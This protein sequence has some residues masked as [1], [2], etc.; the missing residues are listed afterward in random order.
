MADLKQDRIINIDPSRI[1][2]PR[3]RMPQ[4]CV[5]AGRANEGLRADWQDQLREAKKACG[6]RYIRMH[7]L[8][9][10]DMGVCLRNADGSLSFS[11]QYIDK[12][13]DFLLSIDVKPFVELSFTP[14]ALA[15]NDKTIFWWKGNVS[16]PA[17]LEDWKSLVHAFVQHVTERYGLAEVSQWYFECWNEPDLDGFFTGTQEDYFHL[18]TATTE[19]VKS[20]SPAYRCGGP[21]TSGCMWIKDFLDYCDQ[22]KTA[23]DFIAT[24]TYGVTQGALDEFGNSGTVLAPERDSI[25]RD[26]IRV[27]KIIEASAFPKLELHFT[28]W[29]SS[30][31]PSDPFHDTWQSPAWILERLKQ[32]QGYIDSMSYWVFTDI[33]EEAGP[34]FTPF[35]GGFGLMNLQGIKKAAWYAWAWHNALGPLELDQEDSEAW[36]CKDDDGGL[37]ILLW[38]YQYSHPGSDEITN[39]VFYAQDLPPQK[40]SSLRLQFHNLE[41][42]PYGLSVYRCGYKKNDPYTFWIAMGKPAQL[43]RTQQ[44]YLE[45]VSDGRPSS[46]EILKPGADGACVL[47]LLVE[48]NEVC[49]IRLQAL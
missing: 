29:S 30:Y 26:A 33:F 27:R 41:N 32:S 37:Q 9:H 7:A 25:A 12:L 45:E 20:V 47:D 11:W 10:D 44:A 1:R 15:S 17:S 4:Y 39:Q 18:Y 6:F 24:H 19:A 23:L 36:V 8:F 16:V 22:S 34:R 46:Q 49:F 2:G 28:E 3:D 35:H 14:W 13:Y 31:T 40:S 38:D 43:T 5:G 42:R 48:E 21:A